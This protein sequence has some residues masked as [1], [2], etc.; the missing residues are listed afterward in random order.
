MAYT[1]AIAGKGGTGK[2]TVASLVLAYLLDTD[3]VPILAVDADPNANFNEWL[4]VDAPRTLGDIQADM[5]KTRSDMPAAMDKRRHLELQLQMALVEESGY[6][7]LA[8]GRSEGPGC[9]CHLN[10]VL[11]AFI[12]ELTPNYPYVV[13]DNEAGM[14][15]LSRRTTRNVDLLL[16]VSDQNPVA[17]RSAT[18]INELKDALEIN[19]D[20]TYLLLN[21]IDGE[22]PEPVRREVERT[23]LQLAG[24]IPSD[25][26]LME[27]NIN[28]KSLL[29]LPADSPAPVAIGKVL[30]EILT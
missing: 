9:Y 7:L 17:I 19:V 24:T 10:D 14:E 1:I 16:I 20:E 8:M 3:R 11:R 29:D 28:G 4:G 2:T 26:E 25:S 21:R 12:D 18:R 13:M 15:H 27:F 6:D 22:I 5:M 30:D 23:G